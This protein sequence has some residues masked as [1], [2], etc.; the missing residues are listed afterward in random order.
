MRGLLQPAE[1][2]EA[3]GLF[4]FSKR[5][6]GETSTAPSRTRGRILHIKRKG[7]RYKNEGRAQV[8]DIS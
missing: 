5:N 6:D 8:S 1:Y 4:F 7:G 3:P 2:L